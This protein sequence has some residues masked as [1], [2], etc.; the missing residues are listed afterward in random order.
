LIWPVR[1]GRSIFARWHHLTPE[2]GRLLGT[3]AQP[4]HQHLMEVYVDYHRPT[5]WLAWMV[6]TLMRNEAPFQFPIIPAE[7]FAARALILDESAVNWPRSS[8]SRGVRRTRIL[9]AKLAL[10]L[11]GRQD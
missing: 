7:I 4:V 1:T 3:Y 10:T 5:W 11:G 2:D 6:E 9:C 8:T